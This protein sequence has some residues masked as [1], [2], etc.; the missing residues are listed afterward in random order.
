MKQIL[1][2]YIEMLIEL[3]ND[4]VHVFIHLFIMRDLQ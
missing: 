3:I 1:V 4:D 2:E